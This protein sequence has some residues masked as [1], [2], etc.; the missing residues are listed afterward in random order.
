M[1]GI[2]RARLEERVIR[3]DINERRFLDDLM[4]AVLDRW[5]VGRWERVKVDRDDR[6]VVA[7][8]R[9]VAREAHHRTR[10]L[11]N[12]L[13]AKNTLRACVSFDATLLAHLNC[14][15]YFRDEKS[16]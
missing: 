13:R 8:R 7:V 4:D 15:T 9:G 12:S 10:Q 1:R 11:K 2:R 6:H 16:P 14:S 3:Q 5:A